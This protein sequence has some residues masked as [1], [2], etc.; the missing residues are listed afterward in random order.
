[1]NQGLEQRG[2]RLQMGVKE[3]D[4]DSILNDN[5]KLSLQFNNDAT[6]LEIEDGDNDDLEFTTSQ[7][8]LCWFFGN[9]QA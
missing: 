3:E 7:Q 5:S 1:M 2:Y 8:E 6:I 4:K 9:W